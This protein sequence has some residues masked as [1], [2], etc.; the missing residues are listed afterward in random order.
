MIIFELFYH[1]V[2]SKMMQY[3]LPPVLIPADFFRRRDLPAD[4]PAFPVGCQVDQQ[5]EFRHFMADQVWIGFMI[6]GVD[7]KAF[8]GWM[9]YK[10]DPVVFPFQ[11]LSDHQTGYDISDPGNID[12]ACVCSSIQIQASEKPDIFKKSSGPLAFCTC[13]A[14]ENISTGLRSD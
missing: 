7:E 5:I 9:N 10:G 4:F 14:E 3:K 6:T 11:R 8:K 13:P 1:A 2:V 12:K